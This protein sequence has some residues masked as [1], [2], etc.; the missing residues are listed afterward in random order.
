MAYK[1]PGAYLNLVNNSQYNTGSTPAL[2]PLIMGSGAQV[3]KRTDVITR[4]STGEI[5]LLP[6]SAQ[7]ILSV[8]T[9]SKKATWFQS[10]TEPVA[11]KD[12]KF[13]TGENKITWET[14]C[15]TKPAAGESYYITYTYKVTEN[16]YEPHLITSM[17]ELKKYYGSD[18]LEFES[19]PTSINRL[20]VAAQ[21]AYEAGNNQPIYVLQV[22][23]N[24]STSLATA[25]EYKA[26]LNNHVRFL[27]NV[28]R[29][30]PVDTGAEI[31]NAIN[32][33]IE[34]CSSYEERKERT[35]I[36]GAAVDSA[37]TTF[38]D[39]M[40]KIGDYAA[41][42]AYKRVIIPYPDSAT[43][44]LS[45]GKYHQ[46][47]APFVAA[48][49]AGKDCALPVHQSMTRSEI[50]IFNTLKG[51]KMSRKQMNMLA[52]KGVMILTQ[53]AGPGTPIVIR[54]QLTTDMTS[55]QTK[56]NSIVKIGDYCSKY[57]RTICEQYIGK[58]NITGET[59]ARIQAG[60]DGGIEALKKSK[61]I[62]AG[63]VVNMEQDTLN[64][65]SLLIQIRITPPYPC[66]YIEIT[67]FLD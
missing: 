51:V 25:V 31:N 46:V 35:A 17:D 34:E 47:D 13:V 50:S 65:D 60:L 24:G 28:W 58:Y 55:V 23:P 38:E 29:I 14:T 40:S 20:F 45:D 56:E 43:I 1:E 32:A 63:T 12:F 5:D 2:F 59:I 10:T 30:V 39:V 54:H 61:I 49:I 57:L 52:E 36:Y 3:L 8:G 67:L 44:L 11:A 53:D 9:T 7:S 19:D 41:A 42:K 21:I 18:F 48:A 22:P 4:A 64:P 33:H 26:A 27:E 16:Q 66:N 37:P 6:M 15:L 62:T